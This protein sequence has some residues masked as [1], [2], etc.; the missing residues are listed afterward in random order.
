MQINASELKMVS[1]MGAS[2]LKYNFVVEAQALYI[3]LYQRKSRFLHF[4]NG[5]SNKPNLVCTL[6]NYLNY[7]VS[8]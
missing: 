1:Y 5:S 8:Y 6:L 4:F 3:S 2:R 7:F